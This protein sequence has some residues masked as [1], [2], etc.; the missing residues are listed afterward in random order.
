MR[1]SRDRV[2]RADMEL[3]QQIAKSAPEVFLFLAIAGGAFLGR[4]R[5]R[6]FMLGTTACTLF[7]S[8]ILGQFGAVEIPP[9][10]KTVF[11]GFF[12][13]TIGFRSGPEFFASLSFR[14][15]AQVLMAL[16]IGASGLAT[17]L[18]FTYIMHLDP[19]TSAGLGAGAMTQSSILGTASGALDQ[20]GLSQVTLK[21]QQANLAAGYAITYVSGYILVL[22]FV[23]F[24]APIL[25]GIDLKAEAAKLEAALSKGAPLKPSQLCYR[26]F[27][28][29]AFRVS[30]A[31]GRSI[32]Q[33]EEQIGRRATIERLVRDGND[34][35]ISREATLQAG[36]EILFA[37]PSSVLVIASAAI[38]VEIEGQEL[39]STT[40]GQVATV[41][42]TSP[43][44]HGRTLTEVVDKFGESARGIFLR[45]VTR[46]GHE[47]PLGPQ[48]HIYIGDV[49]TLVGVSKE[50]ERV[51]K[52][53][54]QIVR[55]D[56]KTDIAFICIGLAV[57]WLVGLV[58]YR[59]GSVPMTLGGAGGA[60]IAG[61]V[62]GWLRSRKPTIGA[63]PPAAQQTLSDIGLSAFIAA[64]GLASGP[65]ALQAIQLHGLALLGAGIT[66]TLVPMIGGTLFAYHILRM[67]PVIICGALAGAMTVD[68]AVNGACEVAKNQTPV[69][70]VAVPYA[71][72]NV[73]L[74]MIGPIIIALT[75]V[76]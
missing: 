54:G 51:A 43:H 10:L 63:F 55:S 1:L 64:I 26:K 7:L 37:G 69:L 76:A 67:N 9:V 42:V 50:I 34:L 72:S 70:G 30:T 19:G 57:G 8:V 15:L 4:L 47:V 58:T 35:P 32:R 56:D 11:F 60:L 27:Q 61:L 21:Q 52:L 14:T 23:P 2:D 75:F 45:T 49:M 22:I 18:A 17:I 33:V 65:A 48:T 62:C 5:I 46:R 59:A 71:I 41:Y 3:I 73:V 6:G 20:L 39:M 44:L 16:F 31:A 24:I 74:T 38:G 68:A 53:L 13:F 36:D 12:V 28:V 25:M 40:T 29:R 66:V